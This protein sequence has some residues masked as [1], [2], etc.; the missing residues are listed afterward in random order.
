MYEV[1]TLN[2]R[3]TKL[4]THLIKN[5]VNTNEN[6]CFNLIFFKHYVNNCTVCLLI[7]ISIIG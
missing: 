5:F 3:N 2:K 4:C 6:C 7:L 1:K